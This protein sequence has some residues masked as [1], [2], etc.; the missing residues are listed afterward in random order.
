MT[1]STLIHTSA[2][3]WGVA[4]GLMAAAVG[5]HAASV[6]DQ[7]GNVGYDTAQECDAAVLNGQARYYKTVERNPALRRKGEAKVVRTTLADLGSQYARGACDLGAKPRMG[8]NGVAKALQGRYVPFAPATPVNAYLD[9]SGK[10]VRATMLECDNNFSESFPRPVAPPVAVAP[11]VAPVVAPMAPPQPQPEP[12]AVAPM[13]KMAPMAAPMAATAFPYVFGTLGAQ[14]DLQNHQSQVHDDHDSKLAAQGG[15]GYQFSDL[16][17]LEGYAQ[18][19]RRLDFENLTSFKTA[20]LGLRATFG[21][22]VG[23]GLRLFSKLGVARVKHTD[24]TNSGL[25]AS[26]VRP[27]LGLGVLYPMGKGLSLRADFD[28]YFKRSSDDQ[29]KW[30]TLNYLGAGVQYAF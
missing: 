13:A 28:H 6:T 21:E 5:V 4:A 29:P 9:A 12:R 19:G 15:V 7:H 23:G 25:T 3:R 22:D 11:A 26:Q 17:G 18:G 27:T 10:H 1:L 24:S 16:F 14:R 30:K 8:R 2:R 20:V